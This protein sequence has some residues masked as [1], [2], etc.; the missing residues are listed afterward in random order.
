MAVLVERVG[1]E[2]RRTTVDDRVLVGLAAARGRVAVVG[3]A[4]RVARGPVVGAGQVDRERVFFGAGG[5]IRGGLVTGV[6]T[7]ALPISE[8]V[9]RAGAVAVVGVER[10]GDRAG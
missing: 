5:G 9:R 3:A 1:D 2:R 7:C 6:Q 10:E 4:T 8:R